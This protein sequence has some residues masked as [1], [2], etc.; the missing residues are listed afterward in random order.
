MGKLLAEFQK[1]EQLIRDWLAAARDKWQSRDDV[2]FELLFCLCTPQSKA[3]VCRAA[4]NKLKESGLLEAAGD[5]DILGHLAG[6]RFPKNKA[7]YIAAAQ[8]K[9][10]EIFGKIQ[11]MHARPPELRDWLVQ[12]VEG[13]GYKEASHFLRNIGLGEELAILDVHI[14]RELAENGLTN[15]EE[16]EKGGLTPRRYLDVEKKFVKA[17]RGLGLKPAELDIAIW[18]S[19]SGNEEIM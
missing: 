12:N 9:F 5:K 15:E 10:S 3:P 1:R 14:M 8:A 18:L 11:A 2:L 6:V 17:A 7:R 4:I 13:Y 19:R 16:G